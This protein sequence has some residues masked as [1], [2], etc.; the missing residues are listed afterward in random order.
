[1]RGPVGRSWNKQES[2]GGP[3]WPTPR[4]VCDIVDSSRRVNG[5]VERGQGEQDLEKQSRTLG[6]HSSKY[7]SVPP[8]CV[9]SKVLFFSVLS[10]QVGI[11]TYLPRAEA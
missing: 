7:P 9:W 6:C 11:M 5:L 8:T 1:M 4:G 2:G 10:L 3:S